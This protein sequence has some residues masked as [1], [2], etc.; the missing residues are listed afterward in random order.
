MADPVLVVLGGAVVK[1]AVRFWVGPNVLTDNLAADLT[2]LLESRVSDA[3]ERRKLRRRFEEMENIVADQVLSALEVEFR[4]LDE[5]ERNAAV[6]AVTETFNR[7]RVTNA[8][9]F[10]RDLDPLNLEKFVRRFK[11]NATRDLSWGG[12]QLSDRILARCCGYI[13]EIAD[14][15][16]R[17][18][19][20]AF[21][22]LLKR[23][24][25][26]LAKIEDVLTRLPVSAADGDTANHVATAYRQRIA[27]VFDRLGL[28]GL[29]FNAQW[30]AL[31]IAYV[32]LTVSIEQAT[33]DQDEKFQ[34][35]LA[36]CPRLLIEGLHGSGKTTIL[37]WVSVQAARR[38]F[39]G[40]ASQFNE[41]IPFFVRL[42]EY[43]GKALPQPEE[44]LNKVAP[45]LAPECHNWPREQLRSGK[46]FVLIDGLDEVPQT[47]RPAVLA[48]VNDLTELFQRPDTLSLP[49]RE[50]SRVKHSKLLGSYSPRSTPWTRRKFG[51]LS[52][53]GI[54]LWGNG[55][56]MSSFKNN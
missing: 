4:G 45:L 26:I 23:D 54:A 37:Q 50:L 44:F 13:L 51:P 52:T 46:A 29:D 9:L 8:D 28:F 1:T 48:W 2:D 38:E 34:E 12:T 56:R 39:E 15:L 5:G 25:Q 10:S 41:H 36:R 19:T 31:T 49:G 55:K 6:G 35:W 32:N 7:A 42:R 18:Q 21:A 33:E 22:E 14:K 30:Y 53:G 27:K 17:F 24:S 43:A 47:Q 11:G 3:R 40:S 20:G 16:P